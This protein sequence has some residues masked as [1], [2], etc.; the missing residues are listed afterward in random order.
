[1]NA[2]DMAETHCIYLR[3]LPTPCRPPEVLEGQMLN[4]A[5][6]NRLRK[7]D[8]Q[9][10]PLPRWNS[11]LEDSFKHCADSMLADRDRVG[12]LEE[13]ASFV[14]G[15]PASPA[16]WTPAQ[17]ESLQLRAR[18]LQLLQ[19]VV[20][21]DG[22]TSEMVPLRDHEFAIDELVGDVVGLPDDASEE[23]KGDAKGDKKAET[24]EGLG[25]A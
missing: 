16:D 24:K 8:N 12:Q 18:A 11:K 15:L 4:A 2:P 1:M 19:P 13:L 9:N 7:L 23:G 25:L 17:L 6:P 3:F 21:F 20:A 10:S 22:F 14:T 5:L